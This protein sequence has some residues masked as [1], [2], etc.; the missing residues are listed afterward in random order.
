M[1]SFLIT[2][3][4]ILVIM[5]LALLYLYYVISRPLGAAPVQTKQMKHLFSIYGYGTKE[6]ELLSR[7]TD[8]SFDSDGNIYIADTGHARILVFRSSGQYLRKIGKKGFGKGELAEPTGVTVSK[9]GDVYVADKHLSKVVI[10]DKNGD[11]KSEL[12][13]MVPFKPH[14]ANGRLYLTTYGHV[15]IYDLKGRLLAKWGNR[16][17]ERGNLDCPTGVTVNTSGDVFVADT[18]NL[19][20]QAFSR[21]GEVRWVKGKPAEDIKAANRSFGLPCGITMDDK[22]LIYL[23]DAFDDSIRVL[24]TKGKQIAELGKKGIKEGELNKPSSIAYDQDG[25][26]AIA[27]KFNDR[28]QVV[29]ITVK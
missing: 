13:V 7:P 11:T 24:D 8:V 2:L 16:G 10:Y 26:F 22:N 23:A 28:V 4:A 18:L 17:R 19:R 9:N 6:D 20:L 27:D 29:K 15:M 5:T 25:V 12:K 3:L 14:V 1:R 21:N